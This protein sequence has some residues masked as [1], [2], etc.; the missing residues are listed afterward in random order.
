MMVKQKYAQYLVQ[1]HGKFPVELEGKAGKAGKDFIPG[2]KA[3]HVLSVDETRQ[4]GMFAVDCTWLWSGAAKAP[5]GVP[6]I[7]DFDQIIGIAGG[8]VNDPQDLGGEISVWLDGR[9]EKIVRNS[10]IVV[11]AGV[12][13]GPYLFTKIDRPIFFVSIAN[14]GTATRTV[15]KQVVKPERE[16]KYAIVDYLK[17]KDFTVAADGE[18]APPPPPRPNTSD[19]CR[20]LHVEDDIVKGSFYV[21]FVWIFKGTGGAPAIP[22]DHEWPE[23]LAM[24]GADP[25]KPYDNGGEMNITLGD[26]TYKTDKSTLVCI[27]EHVMH[28]PWGFRDIKSPSLIFSAGPSSVYT[29]SHKKKEET[30]K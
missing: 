18:K 2:V 19:G 16:R 10:L 12:V 3:A 14:K 26:E 4:E 27:P 11:P 23:V 30:K 21:D 24:L 13:H 8:N 7:H 20:I 28:C 29:G 1:D 17:K 22:H 9:F 25:D 6:H 5:V 15:V